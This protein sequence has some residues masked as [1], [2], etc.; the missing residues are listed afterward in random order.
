[1][2][3]EFVVSSSQ[4]QTGTAEETVNAREDERGEDVFGDVNKLVVF[5]EMF[6][7][8]TFVNACLLMLI[9]PREPRR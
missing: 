4:A 8:Y 7:S 5:S 6:A 9:R 1:M 3:G 2:E